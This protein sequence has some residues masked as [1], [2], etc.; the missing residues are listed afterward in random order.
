MSKL[1]LL[2]PLRYDVEDGET[3]YSPNG[4]WVDSADF[5]DLADAYRELMEE[6]ARL[7][8]AMPGKPDDTDWPPAP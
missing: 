3:V 5:D 7:R 6:N 1:K 4:E 2:N 8:A